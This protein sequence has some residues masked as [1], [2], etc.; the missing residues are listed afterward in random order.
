MDPTLQWPPGPPPHA[1]PMPSTWS[2]AISTLGW[3]RP[4]TSTGGC[5]ANACIMQSSVH[6]KRKTWIY[7]LTPVYSFI[8]LGILLRLKTQSPK[9]CKMQARGITIE[10]LYQAGD[11][12]IKPGRGLKISQSRF[13]RLPR[14]VWLQENLER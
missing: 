7:A 11:G 12:P 6:I 9:G 13:P 2:R 5:R 3:L 10:P 1:H 14:V 4:C 8:P